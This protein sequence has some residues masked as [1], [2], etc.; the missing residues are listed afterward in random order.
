MRTRIAGDIIIYHALVLAVVVAG[1]ACGGRNGSSPNNPG[2]PTPVTL[3]VTVTS[4]AITGVTQLSHPGDTSQLTMIATFSDGT[5]RDVTTEAGWGYGGPITVSQSGL[6]TAR[7]YGNGKVFHNAFREFEP[8]VLEVRVMPEG[9]FMVTG[10]VREGGFY[11]ENARVTG[12]STSGTLTT[13]S[14]DGG[15]KLAPVSGEVVV[16]VDRDGYV[17]QA[18]TLTV[19][20]DEVADF[21][22]PRA[23]AAANG[24]DGLYTLTITAASSCTLPREFMQRTY[25]ARITEKA[26]GL[27][28]EVDG[29]GIRNDVWPNGFMGQR[30]GSTVRFDVVGD[31]NARTT[32]RW[33]SDY[34]FME[35]LDDV[36]CMGQTCG[37]Q[38][39]L[40]YTGTAT[41][42]IGEGGISTVV[43]GTVRLW[44]DQ[45]WAQCT[46]DHRLE[47]VRRGW[48]GDRDQAEGVG[49]KES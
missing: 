45:P 16:R 48:R 38:R 21:E 4:I 10:R 26:D 36:C 17:A 11:V 31:P 15:Y 19:Q 47:L 49:R 6:I 33:G 40:G 5:A 37:R 39:F 28:V 7:G 44:G 35:H 14:D 18:K 24:I 13:T 2:A 3:P 8:K 41:G 9:S 22:L 1:M 20:R 25:Q 32:W 12:T 46:G 42:T 34:I 23:G 29:L 43:N 30:D 27:L